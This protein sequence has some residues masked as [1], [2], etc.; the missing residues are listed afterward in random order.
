MRPSDK[1][2]PCFEART[3]LERSP[4]PLRLVR[5]EC[6][7]YQDDDAAW[8]RFG[9]HFRR[10]QR[11]AAAIKLATAEPQIPI[12]CAPASARDASVRSVAAGFRK[13]P[14]DGPP[15]L[16]RPGVVDGA[17]HGDAG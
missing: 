14:E 8:A 3:R 17:G 1:E 9:A 10:R 6:V 7:G 15:S 5:D 2:G 12:T 11:E 16:R 4:A 13:E